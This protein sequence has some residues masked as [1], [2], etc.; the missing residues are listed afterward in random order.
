MSD[1]SRTI[2]AGEYWVGDPC[3]AFQDHGV[4]MSLLESA[5]GGT[6]NPEEVPQIMEAEAEGFS[7]VASGTMFGDGEYSSNTLASFPVDAGM[8]GVVP[9]E[10]NVGIPFGMTRFLFDEPFTVS[11]SDD[12][13]IKIGHIEIPT[14]DWEVEE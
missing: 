9:T 2:P 4:W 13:T 11:Y 1:V 12:G 6:L 5:W 8:I 14:G 3:Y 7:F 10:A